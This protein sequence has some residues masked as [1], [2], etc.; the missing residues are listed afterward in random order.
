MYCLSGT[1]FSRKHADSETL[2]RIRKLKQK[3][4]D[5][6][7]IP[8]YVLK[9]KLKRVNRHGPSVHQEE[10][11]K[12]WSSKKALKKR[13][14]SVHDRLMNDDMHRASQ[15]AIHWT[16]SICLRMDAL[17]QEHHRKNASRAERIRYKGLWCFTLN[18]TGKKRQQ[19]ANV[20]TTRKRSQNFVRRKKQP[21]LWMTSSTLAYRAQS[22]LRSDLNC[23]RSNGSSANKHEMHSW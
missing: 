11:C 5:L 18:K 7:T 19:L 3:R 2:G 6:L 13:Y 20:K 22:E 10:Y 15:L 4:F 1:T 17:A 12:R 9:K 8:K 14:A 21:L 16:E 23:D